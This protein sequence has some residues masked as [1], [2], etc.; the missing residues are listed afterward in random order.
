M[1]LLKFILPLFI[2]TVLI[3]CS[4]DDDMPPVDELEGLTIVQEITND[5]HVVELYTESGM[6]LLGYNN[7]SLKIK[8]IATNSYVE[9]ASITWTPIMHMTSMMHS[10][11]FSAIE[12]VAGTAEV[13]NGYIVF[14]MPENESEGWMLTVNYTINGEEYSAEGSVSVPQTT[15]Q[16]VSVVTGADDKIYVVALVDPN[17][18]EVKINDMTVGVYTME[19]MMS[20][21]IVE[22]YT[23]DL[24]P[25]MPS[26][27]NHSS[28][29]N[30]N[31]SYNS[32]S[33]M[34]D[35]QLSL[36][37][38]GYWKLNLI[39]RDASGEILK[40]EPITDTNEGSSLYLEIEF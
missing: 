13:Y 39:L 10:C 20:F 33:E 12:K 22:N 18:P 25:R 26:M 6:L 31:L 19:S 35:G 24:D 37:M 17:D 34:Y 9:D 27:G 14:Q 28:P 23:I 8:D 32:T 16:R 2:I 21:P 4:E 7:I 30:E 36:T 40:G 29:N 15:R 11:P 38:T 5:T 3:S 1:K